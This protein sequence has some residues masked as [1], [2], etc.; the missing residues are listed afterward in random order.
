M[1]VIKIVEL[2][3]TVGALNKVPS[4]ALNLTVQPEKLDPVIVI[5]SLPAGSNPVRPDGYV[6]PA[7]NGG[8]SI[9]IHSVPLYCSNLL[10]SVLNLNIPPL[11]DPGRCAVDPAGMS[12]YPVD[13]LV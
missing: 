10:K 2:V 8:V 1:T 4:A 9:V 6:A 13:E 3:V 11:G 5:V 12:K 7:I